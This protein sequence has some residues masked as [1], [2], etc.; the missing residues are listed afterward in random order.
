MTGTHVTCQLSGSQCQARG[1]LA[2]SYV[3]LA[4]PIDYVPLV[5]VARIGHITLKDAGQQPLR[6]AGVEQDP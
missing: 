2:E 6:R 4:G 5:V 3:D 1:E